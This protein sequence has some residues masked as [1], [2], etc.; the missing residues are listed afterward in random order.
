[1]ND[2]GG[3]PSG[4]NGWRLLGKILLGLIG[5]V[6][7]LPGAC[8]AFFIIATLIGQGDSGFMIIAVPSFLLGVLGFWI[9]RRIYL[10]SKVS[11][12]G[13]NP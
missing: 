10:Q 5:V 9:L 13:R 7:L 1:M 8:G 4:G 11:A 2:T 12:A 3:A 6:L